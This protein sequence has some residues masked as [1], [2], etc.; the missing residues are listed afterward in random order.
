M[1][2][3]RQDAASGKH[4]GDQLVVAADL[5][6]GEGMQLPSGVKPR[7][8]RLAKRR[9]LDVEKVVRERQNSALGS[10][11]AAGC[12]SPAAPRIMTESVVFQKEFALAERPSS[13]VLSGAADGREASGQ[14]PRGNVS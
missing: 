7:P 10:R 2:R 3:V 13:P 6:D 8:P 12:E 5:G 14:L 4:A 1:N 9:G 11:N